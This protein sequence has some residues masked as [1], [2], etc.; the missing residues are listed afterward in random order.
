[1]IYRINDGTI[2]VYSFTTG[3]EYNIS[4]ASSRLTNISVLD[5]GIKTH[6]NY[7]ENYEG[8]ILDFAYTHGNDLYAMYER[9]KTFPQII[10]N[11]IFNV[12]YDTISSLKLPSDDSNSKYDIIGNVLLNP[13]GHY[14]NAAET[15]ILQ[16]TAS[17]LIR[18]DTNHV[19]FDAGGNPQSVGYTDFVADMSGDGKISSKT[20]SDGYKRN[21]RWLGR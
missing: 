20:T 14:H 17:E 21:V 10:P 13:P 3:T 5:L 1:M 19:Y 2:K 18:K 15:K 8:N 11:N 7:G 16:Y 9:A 4:N 6:N 12:N